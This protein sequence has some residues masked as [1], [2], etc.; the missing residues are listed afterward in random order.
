MLKLTIKWIVLFL[1]SFMSVFAQ[2]A[3][4]IQHWQTPQGSRV[5]FIENHDL[6]MVDLSVSFPAGSA[7]DTAPQSGLAGLTRYMMTLGAGGLSEE[8]ITNRFADVG[9]VLGGDFDADRASF[10]LRTL[11]S[12]QDKAL[13]VFKKV[14]HQP[15]FPEAV[16]ARE[17]LRIVAG[18]QESATKPEQIAERL[19]MQGLYA[20]HPYALDES[21]EEATIKA[22]RVDDLKQF[23]HTYYTAK[24]AVVA[25][26]GDMSREQAEAIAESLTQGL[27][28]G[29]AIGKLPVVSART[30][31]S[32]EK[33]A[34]PAS[35]AHILIGQ[36]TLKRGD[37]DFFPLYVGNYILGG[38]GFVS[39][40]TEQVRE[41]RGLV[42]SVYSYFSPMAQAGP[43]KIGLQTKKEQADEAL[44]L[45]NETVVNF[46][47][48]GV[49]QKELEAAKSNLIGGFP[50]RIDSNRKLLDYL[51][52]IGFYQ[53]SL[54]YLDAFINGVQ[55]V[56]VEKVNEA[57][58]RRVHPDQFVTVIV[59]A[60]T[61]PLTK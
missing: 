53:L 5:Y 55:K 2:A 37:P 17:K 59:G 42:Y 11:V 35:Q 46:I 57:F 8:V 49:T 15:D 56:T 38:G 39:R 20:A 27:P 31:A 26:V 33:I 43:F 29:E 28:Q 30:Q 3:M 9:A 7:R 41:K 50:M 25:L 16:L 45:V 60:E 34:H 19:F 6:P 61:K 4:P 24:S 18:L 36:A 32:L 52:I 48:K 10:K 13:D 1:C 51:S 44:Q 23:Y 12:E 58:K 21:G 14:L 54:N 22:I 40:L 47:D